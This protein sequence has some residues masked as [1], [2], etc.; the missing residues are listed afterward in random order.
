VGLKG[1][2]GGLAQQV[3]GWMDD[4]RLIG[5]DATGRC[6]MCSRVPCCC[7]DTSAH[8]LH[9][10]LGRSE[11]LALAE[12]AGGGKSS[13][14]SRHTVAATDIIGGGGGAGA[15][16]A[17][18]RPATVGMGITAAL[19]KAVEVEDPSAPASPA[20]ERGGAVSGKGHVREVGQERRQAGG[21]REAGEHHDDKI[22]AAQRLKLEE[23]RVREEQEDAARFERVHAAYLQEQM[24]A[25]C[26]PSPHAGGRSTELAMSAFGGEGPLRGRPSR[27]QCC[28]DTGRTVEW[29]GGGL[30]EGGRRG[31]LLL[32]A[33]RLSMES[34]ERAGSV[35]GTGGG[36]RERLEQETP[37]W[38]VTPADWGEKTQDAT[39]V[40]ARRADE[41]IFDLVGALEEA[42]DAVEERCSGLKRYV[43]RGREGRGKG[44]G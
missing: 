37:S 32:H 5:R 18:T 3:H 17:E 6:L 33:P 8:A 12:S 31:E 7:W 41:W 25:S 14:A 11:V 23:S 28:S 24:M 42:E 9:A 39:R 22:A 26:Q 36:S 34:R 27:L 4:W 1:G 30:R 20:L 2:G 16:G 38:K 21:K 10:A 15:W 19:L 40:A 29:G 35:M 44:W 13:A 43:G